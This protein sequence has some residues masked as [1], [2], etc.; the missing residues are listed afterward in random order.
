[1][2]SQVTHKNLSLGLRQTELWARISVW[3]LLFPLMLKSV[4]PEEISK[5]PNGGVMATCE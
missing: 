5:V 2:S 1:M 4:G 3:L